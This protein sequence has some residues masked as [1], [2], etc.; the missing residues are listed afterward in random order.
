M[1]L[2]EKHQQL[3]LRNVESRPAREVHTTAAAVP[4]VGV[5]THVA[6]ASRRPS[7]GSY[8]KSYPPHIAREKG[9]Y[10]KNDVH[11]GYLK[12]DENTRKEPTILNLGIFNL[13]NFKVIVTNVDVKVIL[14]RIVGHHPISPTCIKNFNNSEPKTD[15]IITLKTPI[16]TLPHTLK[17]LKTT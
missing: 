2:A 3:L 1:L 7:R 5:D 11:K 12:R 17:A 13:D 15:G 16:P 10:G 4:V 6:K 8:R 14:L 9:A